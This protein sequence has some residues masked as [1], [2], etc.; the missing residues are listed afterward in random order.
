MIERVYDACKQTGHDTYVL[1]DDMRIGRIFGWDICWIDQEISYEN[2]TERCA[3]AIGN[4][5][6]A[7]YDQFVNVQGDMP[8]VTVEMIEKCVG[9]LKHYP[10]STV[11]TDMPEE[12]QNNPASV[13]MVRAG[14]QALW[15]GRGMT[16]YGLW[17]LGVY[18]YRRNAL[19]MYNN[20]EVTQEEKVEKLEQL[21]WLKAGWD[22]GCWHTEFSG[23]EINN[24]EDIEKW[25]SLQN[26]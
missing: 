12:E 25:D 8:D 23:V 26:I 14:D 17:H 18:G 11:F 3:G 6:F 5:L 10:V 9:C 15:F 4:D 21:R 24:P 13:K 19:E 1:T 16:G 22:I 2:G 20:L 7:E